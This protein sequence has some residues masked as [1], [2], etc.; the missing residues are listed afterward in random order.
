MGRTKLW[1][2]L[3]RIFIEQLILAHNKGDCYVRILLCVE[4]KILQ[5]CL[6]L[7]QQKL[8]KN[9]KSNFVRAT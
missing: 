7:P 5:S 2:S 9:S 8:S 6:K 1:M 3:G 4:L